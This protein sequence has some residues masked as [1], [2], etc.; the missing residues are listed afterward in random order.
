MGKHREDIDSP[1]ETT[2]RDV[3]IAVKRA[4]GQSLRE[5]GEQVGLSKSRVDAIC[6]R[7]DVRTI[8]ETEQKRLVQLVPTA[9]DNYKTW[10]SKGS[11]TNNKDEREVAFKASTKVL[12]STG[13]L[14]GAPSV[15]IQNVYNDNKTIISPVIMTLL[16][17]FTGKMASFDEEIIDVEDTS[18]EGSMA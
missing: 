12:E 17:E 13:I 14:N 11:I 4:S 18:C 16:K 8:I 15:L 3:E 6:K 2:P 9:I 1:W 7:E 10:I 5:I